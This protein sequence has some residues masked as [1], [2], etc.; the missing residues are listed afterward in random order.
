MAGRVAFA[1]VVFVVFGAVSVAMGRSA[2]QDW[3][4]GHRTHSGVTALSAVE[5]WWPALLAGAVAIGGPIA[6]LAG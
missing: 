3:R 6:I 5:Q 4:E 1:V 2:S